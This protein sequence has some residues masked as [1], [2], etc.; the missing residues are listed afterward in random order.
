M[1]N[2]EMVYVIIYANLYNV[3]KVI[4]VIEVFAKQLIQY[5][6][7]TQIVKLINFVFKRNVDPINKIVVNML[8]VFQDNTVPLVNALIVK[9]VPKLFVLQVKFAKIVNALILVQILFV[10]TL[11][12][13]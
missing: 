6:T 9:I 8:H 13:V 2:V 12:P 5:A 7:Q 10:K 1:N 4:F 3:F 11:R